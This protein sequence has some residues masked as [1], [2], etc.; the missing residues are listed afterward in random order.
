MGMDVENREG[1]PRRSAPEVTAKTKKACFAT[2]EDSIAE[3]QRK[4]KRETRAKQAL[5]RAKFLRNGVLC[6]KTGVSRRARRARKSVSTRTI[7]GEGN[8]AK[9]QNQRIGASLPYFQRLARYER[10]PS[11]SLAMMQKTD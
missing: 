2:R 10:L 11:R 7:S 4:R 1:G 5:E 9:S 8:D 6:G 3:R